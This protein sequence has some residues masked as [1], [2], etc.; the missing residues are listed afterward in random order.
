MIIIFLT[1]HKYKRA[2]LGCAALLADTVSIGGSLQ[3]PGLRLINY[4]RDNISK[5]VCIVASA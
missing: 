1:F 4:K 2:S 5:Y 3:A